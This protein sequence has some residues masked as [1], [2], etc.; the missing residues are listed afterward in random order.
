MWESLRYF[1][2]CSQELQKLGLDESADLYVCEVPV[3][4][5]AVQVLLPV[6][7][8]EHNPQVLKMINICFLCFTW[9]VTKI[10]QLVCFMI[11]C[12]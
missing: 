11:F 5:Q 3:E 12:E 10:Q 6:L 8:K 2:V 9:N 7:W 1:I 4:Y